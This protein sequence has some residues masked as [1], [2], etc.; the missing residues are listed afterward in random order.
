MIFY[1]LSIHLY[2]LLSR[3]IGFKSKKAKAFYKGRQHQTIPSLKE[4]IWIHA[5]SLGEFEQGRTLLESLKNEHPH[6]PI[7]LTF[8]SPS[9][10]E[11]RKDYPFAD[12]ILYLPKDTPIHAKNFLNQINPKIAI[13]IK[14]DIWLNYLKLLKQHKIHT[15]LIAAL[16]RKKQIYFN[17]YFGKIFLNGLKAF[18][19]IYHQNQQS[20]EICHNIGLKNG[21]LSGDTRVDRVASI[22]QQDFQDTY[23]ESWLSPKKTTIVIG[24]AWETECEYIAKYNTTTSHN[25]QIIIAPHDVSK[26]SILKL[27]DYFNG[28]IDKYSSKENNHDILFIDTIGLL[29]KLYRY[30]DFAIIGGGFK[31]SIHNTLEVITYGIPVLFGPNY[32]KFIEAKYL[33]EYKGG[34]TFDNYDDFAAAIDLYISDS[35]ARKN[36]GKIAHQYIINSTGTSQAIAKDLQKVLA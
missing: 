14:Y 11:Q 34:I 8:F 24:S 36:A 3:L 6:L 13:F 31:K 17:K 21:I 32:D 18:D 9:G 28:D 22:Q 30:G 7:V 20:Q 1:N 12:H 19:V 10:Y 5:S 4:S 15:I 33:V 25:I 35:T 16:F 26:H 27:S 29:N 2:F 23:I